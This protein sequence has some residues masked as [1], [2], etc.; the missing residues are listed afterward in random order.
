M[1]CVQQSLHTPVYLPM[2]KW[3]EVLVQLARSHPAVALWVVEM[4]KRD[5]AGMIA[6]EADATA[7]VGVAADLAVD[8][9]PGD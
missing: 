1:T 9:H 6:V 8:P 7:A 2:S 4:N 5:A 3:I